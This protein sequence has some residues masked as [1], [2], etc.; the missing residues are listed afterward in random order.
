MM[1]LHIKNQEADRLARELARRT[2]KSITAAVREALREKLKS[3]GCTEKGVLAKRLIEIGEDCA[4]RL[5]KSVRSR[6]HGTLLYN[7]KGLPK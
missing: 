4:K 1:S 2:G 3:L 7:K 6:Q 5:P